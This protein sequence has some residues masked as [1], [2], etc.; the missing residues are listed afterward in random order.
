MA[1]EVK[2]TKDDVILQLIEKAGFDEVRKVELVDA[3]T[4]ASADKK[5]A[6]AKAAREKQI[7]DAKALIAQ[8]EA[9][10][11]AQAPAAPAQEPVPVPV[12]TQVLE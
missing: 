4:G 8:E 1:D 10:N 3:W 11:A 6:D 7:A 9:A 5:A 2:L 12:N